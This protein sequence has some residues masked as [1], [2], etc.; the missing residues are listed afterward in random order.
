MMLGAKS[1]FGFS[2]ELAYKMKVKMVLV[3]S[4]GR[5]RDDSQILVRK[6]MKWKYLG[7]SMSEH[8]SW[9]LIK[10]GRSVDLHLT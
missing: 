8:H 7:K 5:E 2:N 9:P 6:G 3:W 1:V 10:D 4:C